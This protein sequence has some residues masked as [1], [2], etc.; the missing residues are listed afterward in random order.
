MQ[1]G[2]F[3]IVL[4]TSWTIPRLQ[5]KSKIADKKEAFSVLFAALKVQAFSL[6]FLLQQMATNNKEFVNTFHFPKQVY[7]VGIIQE[8]MPAFETDLCCLVVF[9]FSMI[10]KIQ[11]LKY[12][13]DLS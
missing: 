4:K 9:Q 11:F 5:Y 13:Y 2:W 3:V 1:F 7:F 6:L 12:H 10:L 8:W